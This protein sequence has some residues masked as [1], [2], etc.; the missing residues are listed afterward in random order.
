M[1][2]IESN[3]SLFVFHSET[4]N[5]QF[6]KSMF[7]SNKRRKQEY[8]ERKEKKE[9]QA[10]KEQKRQIAKERKEAMDK[11]R[12]ILDNRERILTESSFYNKDK[13]EKK[14]KVKAGSQ[15]FS[16]TTTLL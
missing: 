8:V 9:K 4:L 14:E 5:R 2:V 13:K 12:D 3:I 10:L 7:G 11:Y 6:L 15:T 16:I 1:K